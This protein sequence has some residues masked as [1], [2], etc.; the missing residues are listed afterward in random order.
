MKF[1]YTM[2]RIARCWHNGKCSLM[3]LLA[4]FGCILLVG[5]A[6]WACFSDG[7]KLPLRLPSDV[8]KKTVVTPSILKV[9]FVTDWEYGYRQRMKHKLTLQS[10]PALEA[11]VTYLNDTYHPDIVVGG[12]D[13]IESTGV[14]PERAREQLAKVDAIFQ[15]LSAPRLYALGNHDLRSLSKADVRE[16]LGLKEN[17]AFR[18]IGDWR[19]VVLD[20]NFNE[21][22]SDRD[23]KQYV[24]GFVNES[25]LS[26]LASVL[27]TE[28]PVLVFSHHSPVMSPN[29]DGIFAVNILNAVSVR[30]VLEEAGNVVGV[31]SGHSPYGY[32]EER[33]GIHYFV[34]D[35]L[36]NEPVLGTFATLD[37]RYA[38]E[39]REAEI[40]FRRVGGDQRLIQV[41]DRKLGTSEN[42]Q[43][44]LPELFPDDVGPET[45]ESPDTEEKY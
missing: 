27:K 8:R 31:V 23:A 19:F 13:Y 38:K 21:D 40:L 32:A 15:K 25:E 1:T 36:A 4:C 35:T 34:V 43:D 24:T 29:V 2:K 11:A 20:T 14:K 45:I 6:G 17:H 22:G 5:I 37:L 18:D 33:N 16:V 9:G 26:W 41:V 30:K 3:V 7:W 44:G 39:T 42:E 28:R 10:L 12:G